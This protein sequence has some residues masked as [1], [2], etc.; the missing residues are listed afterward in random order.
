VWYL[1]IKM[2]ENVSEV[3]G[4]LWGK[5]LTFEMSGDMGLFIYMWYLRWRE[6]LRNCEGR[7]WLRRKRLANLRTNHP[8]PNATAMLCVWMYSVER[9]REGGWEGGRRKGGKEEERDGVRKGG[10]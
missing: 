6:M 9:E 5:A 1:K 7:R 3:K 2:A 10:R 8:M 4:Q